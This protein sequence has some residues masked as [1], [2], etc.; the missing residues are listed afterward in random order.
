MTELNE[1]S[2]AEAMEMYE[3]RVTIA[4]VTSREHGSM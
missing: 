4:K 2:W 1:R 3:R